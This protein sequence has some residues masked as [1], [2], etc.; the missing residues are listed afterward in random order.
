MS[1]KKYIHIKLSTY[2]RVPK[3]IVFFKNKKLNDLIYA[4]VKNWASEDCI[5]NVIYNIGVN[6]FVFTKKTWY[7]YNGI[8][9]ELDTGKFNLLISSEIADMYYN[10]YAI[11]LTK[12]ANANFIYK[13]LKDTVYKK[14]IMPRLQLLF[15]DSLFE[16]KLDKNMSLL[17][18]DN[19][20]YDFKKQM[21]RSGLYKDYISNSTNYHFSQTYSPSMKPLLKFLNEIIPN[22]RHLDYLLKYTA[23][24]LVNK[25]RSPLHI[26]GVSQSGKSSYRLLV[27]FSFGDYCMKLPGNVVLRANKDYLFSMDKLQTTKLVF[28]EVHPEFKINDNLIK[29]IEQDGAHSI[30]YNLV[31]KNKSLY[32]KT[33]Y[34]HNGTG[35]DDCKN[36]IMFVNKFSGES[37]DP[38]LLQ[39]LQLWRNDFFLLL[40]EKYNQ[41]LEFRF[42]DPYLNFM[43]DNTG[44]SKSHIHMTDLY[45]VFKKWHKEKPIPNIDSFI[46][47]VTRH[48]SVKEIEINGVRDFG[49]KHIKVCK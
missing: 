25:E 14:K 4:S 16:E 32:H 40:L 3:K 42:N 43:C 48:Y 18:F 7:A 21:F 30:K 2:K 44:H 36:K 1:D 5:T 37:K 10:I 20:V 38:P 24:S 19:G 11:D 46:K 22:K 13:N 9:W 39:K 45:K 29:F 47:G 27:E 15:M 8:K 17:G 26:V 31:H 12:Y 6:K 41:Y 28:I 34:I 23:L 33:I 49:I 35:F